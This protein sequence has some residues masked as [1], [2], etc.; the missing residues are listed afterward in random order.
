M[1]IQ[2]SVLLDIRRM[3][4]KT[5]KYPIKLR[6]TY[7]R[8]VQYYQTIYDLSKEEYKKPSSPRI[9]QE[10]KKIRDQLHSIERHAEA[11]VDFERFN[12]TE[13]EKDYILNNP[14]F[15]QR[16]SIRQIIVPKS[17][18]FDR[19]L[20]LHRFPIF[21]EE[22]QIAGTIK[23]VFLCYI[24]KL[25]QEHRIRTAAAYQTAYYA[26]PKYRGNMRFVD[27]TVSYLREYEQ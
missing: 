11:A 3:K 14:L 10:L 2:L 4:I 16:K 27:I 19:S 13:F 12:F 9:S 26:I 1:S 17:F 5:K 25:L 22:P 7:E 15:H 23:L 20:Y 8:E 21:K 18:Q 24:D 6:V